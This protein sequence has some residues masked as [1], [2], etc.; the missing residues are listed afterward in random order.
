MN[1]EHLNH[2]WAT[3]VISFGQKTGPYS[4]RE[5]ARGAF[6]G[7][8][9]VSWDTARREAPRYGNAP[10]YELCFYLCHGL[11][12]LMGYNDKTVKQRNQMHKMQAKTLKKIGLINQA[13]KK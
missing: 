10:L 6:L 12:H 7:D 4:A 8:I 5:K 2:D 11:L 1:K 9:V 3:D 13:H